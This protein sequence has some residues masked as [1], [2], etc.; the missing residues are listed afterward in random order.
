MEHPYTTVETEGQN[1]GEN[2]ANQDVV[3]LFGWGTSGHEF[4]SEYSQ[5]YQPNCA[6]PKPDPNTFPTYN[7]GPPSPE[8]LTGTYALG[9][10]GV[11]NAIVNGSVTDPAGTWRTPTREELTYIYKTRSDTYRFACARV[12]EVNGLLLFPD[13][14]VPPAGITI[15]DANNKDDGMYDTNVLT[16]AN[17]DK[18][19]AAG[20]IFLPAAG[21]RAFSVNSELNYAGYYWT[22]SR[23]KT[24]NA[25]YT[26]VFSD[27]GYDEGFEG[28]ETSVGIMSSWYGQSVRLVRDI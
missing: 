5:Y 11:K 22:S 26:F 4:D 20:V 13:G 14:F 24:Y 12:H 21:S 2:Y 25:A 18:L 6:P 8:S 1:V 10:W 19:A 7:Y 28:V 27:Y 17:W 16:D 15:N 3:S 9:D 23:N